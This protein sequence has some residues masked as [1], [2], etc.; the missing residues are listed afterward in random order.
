MNS[1]FEKCKRYIIYCNEIL[2]KKNQRIYMQDIFSE[3]FDDTELDLFLENNNEHFYIST[4]IDYEDLSNF[5][6]V[7]FNT[8]SCML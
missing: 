5:L 1:Y 6:V 8:I 2:L 4:F 7:F 3:E